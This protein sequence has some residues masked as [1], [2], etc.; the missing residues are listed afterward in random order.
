MA[1]LP[2]EPKRVLVVDDDTVVRAIVA[3]VA[4][5]LGC[6][7]LEARTGAEA[8]RVLRENPPDLL[9]LDGLLPDTDGMTWLR[10][11]RAQGQRVP[12]LFSSAFWKDRHSL[13]TLRDELG[14]SAV[15]NKPVRPDVLGRAMA[16]A[17]GIDYVP[18]ASIPA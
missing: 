1:T 2:A 6:S 9:V 3:Q 12:V 16:T 15:L 17:L 18:L 5:R 10:S 13:K 4:L 11:E 8:S 7:T 14:V